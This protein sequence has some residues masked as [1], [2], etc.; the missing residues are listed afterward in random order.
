MKIYQVEYNEKCH[1]FDVQGN[2]VKAA[3]GFAA[4]SYDPVV[5]L[6]LEAKTWPLTRRTFADVLNGEEWHG[7]GEVFYTAKAKL[8]GER[9]E[10]EILEGNNDNASTVPPSE[11]KQVCSQSSEPPNANTCM[12][13]DPDQT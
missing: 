9:P 4:E 3:R 11:A 13:I 8:T 12:L 7:E 6:A 5:V 10:P 2:A 1:Y